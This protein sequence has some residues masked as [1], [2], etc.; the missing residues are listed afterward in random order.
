MPPAVVTV[1]LVT[2]GVPAA[3]R[4]L[5]GRPRGLGAA[6]LASLAAAAVAQSAGEL[7]GCRIGVLGDAQVLLAGVG[8][9]LA[10]LTVAAVETRRRPRQRS[11]KSAD[12]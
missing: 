4:A 7:A 1:A 9:T 5:L 8:A 10:S 11:L 12:R 6:W 3:L 2:I